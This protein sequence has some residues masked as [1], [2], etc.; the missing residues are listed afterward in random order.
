M[1]Q[2]SQMEYALDH[3]DEMK[4]MRQNARKKILRKY[5]L[6]KLL[7]KQIEYINSLIKK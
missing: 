1:V 4:I 7:P 5:A 3:K 2:I 6:N